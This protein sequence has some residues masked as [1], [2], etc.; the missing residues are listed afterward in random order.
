FYPSIASGI[1]RRVYKLTQSWVHVLITHGFLRSLARL[2]LAES[3]VGRF[4]ATSEASSRFEDVPDPPHQ[5]DAAPQP[6]ARD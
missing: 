4:A 1:S 2:D 3:K 6:A 5:D